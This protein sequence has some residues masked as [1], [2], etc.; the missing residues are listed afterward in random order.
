MK[1]IS[2]ALCTTLISFSTFAAVDE[3]TGQPATTQL[4]D[5]LSWLAGWWPV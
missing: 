4:T 1:K 2:L 3:G 5:W